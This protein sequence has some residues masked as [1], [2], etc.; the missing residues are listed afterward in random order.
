MIFY[1]IA[2]PLNHHYPTSPCKS[3][4]IHL[5]R[6]DRLCNNSG[7][8]FWI[9]AAFSRQSKN[10]ESRQG[11]VRFCQGCSHDFLLLPQHQ[12]HRAFQLLVRV[13]GC[14]IREAWSFQA[15]CSLPECLN[16]ARSSICHYMISDRKNCSKQ[17][18]PKNI[19]PP[20]AGKCLYRSVR[21]SK[22]FEI[23]F[24]T[25]FFENAIIQ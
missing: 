12:G 20:K 2:Y 19:V 9:A 11:N 17:K 24:V 6:Q 4:H 14:I 15:D 1:P 8:V 23:V 10:P 7:R 18:L 22:L 16:N 21:C 13:G 25:Q 3:T 5:W